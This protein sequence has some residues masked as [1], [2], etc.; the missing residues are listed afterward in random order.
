MNGGGDPFMVHPQ[1]LERC[2]WWKWLIHWK[3]FLTDSDS[4]RPIL[5]LCSSMISA[6]MK[7]F[8]Y[9]PSLKMCPKTLRSLRVNDREKLKSVRSYPSMVI[10]VGPVSIRSKDIWISGRNVCRHEFELVSCLLFHRTP[11]SFVVLVV[12]GVHFSET[13]WRENILIANTLLRKEI[14]ERKIMWHRRE[15]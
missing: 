12:D 15:A 8:R 7:D 2:V 6:P 5:Q 13:R 9:I 3:R 1:T 11:S 14:I 10:S 4:V